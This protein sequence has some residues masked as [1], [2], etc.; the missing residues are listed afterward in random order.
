MRSSPHCYERIAPIESGRRLPT[1]ILALEPLR[2]DLSLLA[3]PLFV[4]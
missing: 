3:N 1:G 4:V 2:Y